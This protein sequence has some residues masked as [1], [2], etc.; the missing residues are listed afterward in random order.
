MRTRVRSRA[1]VDGN[2]TRILVCRLVSS[3]V[4]LYQYMQVRRLLDVNADYFVTRDGNVAQTFCDQ[5]VTK[6]HVRADRANRSL[7]GQLGLVWSSRRPRCRR[8]AEQLGRDR[9]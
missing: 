8:R 3:P 4:D 6:G 9:H 2:R 7:V 5:T 1:E